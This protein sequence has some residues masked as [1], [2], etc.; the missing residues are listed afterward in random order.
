MTDAVRPAL[1][2]AAGTATIAPRAPVLAPYARVRQALRAELEGG[3]FPPG[4]RMPSEAELVDRFG[5]SR[6]TV[7][8][9]L[10]E[11][12][13]V[14]LVERVQG[15]GTF[16]AQLHQVASTLTIRDLHEEI[17]AR[18]HRHSA[19]V[20][21]CREEP[22]AREVAARLGL[23]EGAPVFH[24]LIVHHEN[25]VPLQCEDRHVNPACAPD[26]LKVDFGTTTPTHYL[27]EVA[28]FGEADYMI[29][30]AKPSAR[31]AKLLGIGPGDPCL[32]VHRRTHGN[33]ATITAARLVHPGAR[34]LLQGRFKP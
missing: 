8:R 4:A 30:A 17:T 28:P 10:R 29:E 19:T 15:V 11:L 16:A 33:G 7:N 27:F 31:E 25:G 5:V 22:A 23:A 13:A 9:A 20:H 6:M 14:G 32:I 21:L 1:H 24:T 12:Q 26:Y 34:Y 3:R 2:S 18:G